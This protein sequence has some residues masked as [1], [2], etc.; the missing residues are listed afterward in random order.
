[1]RDDVLDVGIALRN[2]PGNEMEDDHGVLQGGADGDSK[3][4]VVDEWRMDAVLHRVVA[5]DGA[6]PVEFGVDGFE[7]FGS[8]GAVEDG[9]GHRDAKHAEFVKAAAQL[10]KRC[11]DVWHGEGDEGGELV[12]MGA[13][14]VVI[15]V[16]TEPRGFDGVLEPFGVW[17]ACGR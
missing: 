13:N 2:T 11:V 12:R 1:M 7:L 6:A 9:A 17:R 15:G 3:T 4:E 5:E 8:S 14:E 16:V 10:T